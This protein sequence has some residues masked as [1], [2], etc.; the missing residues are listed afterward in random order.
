MI[1]GLDYQMPNPYESLKKSNFDQ[2]LLAR[3]ETLLPSELPPE[4][5]LAATLALHCIGPAARP[6]R[7]GMLPRYRFRDQDLQQGVKHYSNSIKFSH[8]CGWK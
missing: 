5:D 7:V 1:V 8:V 2:L 4:V 6:A 3:N